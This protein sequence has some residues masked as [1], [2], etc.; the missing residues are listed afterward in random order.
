M[1]RLMGT[2]ANG[3][4][5]S[6]GLRGA[7]MR[8]RP[9]SEGDEMQCYGW[10]KDYECFACAEALWYYARRLGVYLSTILFEP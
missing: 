5:E 1:G 4:I 6:V 7:V 3:A 10:E 2:I 9:M 8:W